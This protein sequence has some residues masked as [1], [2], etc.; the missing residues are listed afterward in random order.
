MIDLD[1]KR[2]ILASASPRRADLLK[3]VGLSF[4][5]VESDLDEN[6]ETYTVPEVH[7]LELSQK[8]ARKV[9]EDIKDGLVVGADTIVV[10]D[11]Q[12]LGKPRDAE[13]A[14]DML[15][16]L[17]GKIHTVYTGFSVV[18][19]PSGEAVSEYERTRVTFRE[20]TDA[21][22]ADYVAS[23]QP[24]DK[25]GAYGIQDRSAL[26]VE[27]IDGCFY[28]VMGFPLTR[29]YCTLQKFLPKIRMAT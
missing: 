17:S 20:L 10:L 14:K 4:D 8:K 18:D 27:R 16:L 19:K 12:I 25:A 3:L 6:E 1:G 23:D 13:E 7:V 11:G 15:R 5:V 21:E 9:A 26:F 28:N 29:F 22:I 24:L 2:L